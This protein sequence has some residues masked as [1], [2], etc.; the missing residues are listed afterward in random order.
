VTFRLETERLLIRPWESADRDAFAALARDPEVTRYVH[1]GTPYSE[2]EI[3]DF[4]AR[5]ARQLAEHK[6][7]MGAM[8]EKESGRVIGVAGIQPLGTTLDLEIGWWLA[9]DDWGRGFATEAGDAAVRHVLHTM[10]R[11][12]VVAII[13][14]P[15]EPSKRVAARLGMVYNRRATGAELGHRKPEIVVD[16]YVRERVSSDRVSSLAADP[17]SS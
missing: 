14:P 11:P 8:A 7:C 13:D 3:D 15:N 10:K 6:V 4:L 9:R 12:R 2:E 1:G 17:V 16:V 5:Q